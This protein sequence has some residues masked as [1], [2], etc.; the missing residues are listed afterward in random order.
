MAARHIRV[1]AAVVRH[2]GKYLITQRR[3]EAVLGGLW[4]FPGGR[5]EAGEADREALA[6]EFEERLGGRLEVGDLLAERHNAYGDYDVTLALY[7]ATLPS[8]AVLETR[9][10]QDFRWVPSD[11]LERYPFPAAD[12]KTMDA[13]LGLTN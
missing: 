4:E 5:V 7:S 2:D 11:E 6:R 12:Q 9:R 3:P 10:V 1:V 8:D 13:L